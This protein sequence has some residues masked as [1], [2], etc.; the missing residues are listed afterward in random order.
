MENAYADYCLYNAISVTAGE[1]YH[2]TIWQ[3]NSTKQN[4]VLL[5]DDN[6]VINERHGETGTGEKSATFDFVIQSGTTKMLLTTR[7]DKTPV[8]AKFV[9]GGAL[10]DVGGFIESAGTVLRGKTV[11]IIGDSISTNGNPG[12]GTDTNAVEL[13]VTAQDVGVQLSAYL[14]YY[15]VQAGLSLGGHTFTSEEIGT[16]VTFTPVS[17]DIGKMIGRPLTYNENT[18]TV[19]WEVM[20]RALENTTIPVCWS[21]A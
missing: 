4:P 14:T 7:N 3:M 18:T 6:L 19:W 17:E 20:Q 12:S 5:T 8:V 2:V 15:D 10:N 16:E 9:T 13:T 11:A 1:R 21:G